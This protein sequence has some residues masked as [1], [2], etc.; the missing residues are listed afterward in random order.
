[1]AGDPGGPSMFNSNDLTERVRRVPFTPFRIHTNGNEDF[2]ITHPDNVLVGRRE[3][4]IGIT[5]PDDPIHFDRLVR[6][7]ILHITSIRDLPVGAPA[8]GDG[9]NGN[10]AAP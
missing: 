3:V 2:D 4:A 10:G 5:L 8:A 7:A 6:V 1:M 9:G